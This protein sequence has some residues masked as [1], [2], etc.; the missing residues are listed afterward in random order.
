[1]KCQLEGSILLR[2]ALERRGWKKSGRMGR[3][4]FSDEGLVIKL[5]MQQQVC[6]QLIEEI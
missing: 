2:T 6:Y 4:R 1:M 5:E 3:F